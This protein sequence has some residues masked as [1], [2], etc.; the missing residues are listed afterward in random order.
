MYRGIRLFLVILRACSITRSLDKAREIHDDIVK[1]SF[2]M[3]QSI[4]NSLIDAWEIHIDIVCKGFED[5]RFVDNSFVDLYAKCGS[6][7]E[8][9]YVFTTICSHIV[10]S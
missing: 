10:V 6:M 7:F 1:A 8:S 3:V 4:S 5:E 2:L 9:Q